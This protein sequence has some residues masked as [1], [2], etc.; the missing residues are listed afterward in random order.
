MR[1]RQEKNTPRNHGLRHGLRSQFDLTIGKLNRQE[2]VEEGAS[3][4]QT[5][6]NYW[7][8]EEATRN[9][10]ETRGVSRP[11]HAFPNEDLGA[12]ARYQC[13]DHDR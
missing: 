7:Q 1:K 10:E 3:T 6:R 2:S 9:K 13:T 5:T 8:K 12:T 4:P 11:L